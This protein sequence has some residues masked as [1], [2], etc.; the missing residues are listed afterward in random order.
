LLSG[1]SNVSS[2]SISG[3]GRVVIVLAEAL[4]VAIEFSGV[5]SSGS[6]IMVEAMLVAISLVVLVVVV[7]V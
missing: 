1:R 2:S 3:V 6:R 7:V 5:G 4:L